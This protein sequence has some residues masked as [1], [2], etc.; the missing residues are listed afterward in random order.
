MNED[1]INFATK[2]CQAHLYTCMQN[3]CCECLAS[4]SVNLQSIHYSFLKMP[5]CGALAAL[6]TLA[7]ITLIYIKYK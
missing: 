1:I 4:D 6:I 2:I 5:V 7:Q 3:N